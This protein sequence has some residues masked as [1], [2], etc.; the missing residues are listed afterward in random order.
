MIGQGDRT[1][2]V[3]MLRNLFF[4][5]DRVIVAIGPATPGG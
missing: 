1:C 3:G 2:A 4:A 5:A